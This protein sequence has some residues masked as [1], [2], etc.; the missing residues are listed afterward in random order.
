MN[1][2]T[3]FAASRRFRG[4]PTV[5][6]RAWCFQR[7]VSTVCAHAR[8]RLLFLAGP[9]DKRNDGEDIGRTLAESWRRAEE[10]VDVMEMGGPFLRSKSAG[11]LL[12]RSGGSQR[13]PT[14]VPA[15]LGDRSQRFE[16]TDS[17]GGWTAPVSYLGA[18]IVRWCSIPCCSSSCSCARP[19]VPL[20]LHP[21]PSVRAPVPA[22]GPR[23][24]CSWHVQVAGETVWN[25]SAGRHCRPSPYPGWLRHRVAG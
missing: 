10:E 2:K 25:S 7:N 6:L 17:A 14:V 23:G 13:P 12:S 21:I 15:R 9:A 19:C 5:Q 8:T 4:D 22:R 3:S 20:P 11:T 24:T 16:T 1:K 18:S